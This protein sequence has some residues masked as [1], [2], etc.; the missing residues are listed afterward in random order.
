MDARGRLFLTLLLSAAFL[1]G[2]SIRGDFVWD[3]RAMIV[4]NPGLD[5]LRNVPRFFVESYFGDRAPVAMY[6]PL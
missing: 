4:E 3:D 6:R 1:H 2:W 5:D